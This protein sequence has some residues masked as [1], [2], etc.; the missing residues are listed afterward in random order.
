MT[1]MDYIND[2]LP[3]QKICI[4]WHSF[5]GWT[6]AFEPVIKVNYEHI[7][8]P[9]A[10]LPCFSYLVRYFTIIDDELYLYTAEVKSHTANVIET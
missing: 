7:K 6:D 1:V 8:L 5:D 4:A 3:T 9:C 2:A 10:A